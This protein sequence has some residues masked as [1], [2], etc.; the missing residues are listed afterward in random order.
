MTKAICPR[1]VGMKGV[2]ESNTDSVRVCGEAV[3]VTNTIKYNAVR[4]QGGKYP[5]YKQKLKKWII[6][7]KSMKGMEFI[8]CPSRI[9]LAS[10]EIETWQRRNAIINQL[11]SNCALLPHALKA[12]LKFSKKIYEEWEMTSSPDHGTAVPMQRANPNNKNKHEQKQQRCFYKKTWQFLE[13][14]NF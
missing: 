5:N 11:N 6:S 3:W 4:V 2:L 10:P 8:T 13:K 1:R 9:L 12:R 14:A 7:V